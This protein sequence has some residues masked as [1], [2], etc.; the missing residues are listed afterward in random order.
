MKLTI[1]LKADIFLVAT[2]Y[3]FPSIPFDINVRPDIFLFFVFQESRPYFFKK[4][5]KKLN[6]DFLIADRMKIV[7]NLKKNTKQTG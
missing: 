7:T 1:K 3:H 6:L 2:K 4:W 5:K